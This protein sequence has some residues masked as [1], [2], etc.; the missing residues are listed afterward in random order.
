MGLSPGIIDPAG[1]ATSPIDIGTDDAATLDAMKQALTA[2]RPQQV[3]QQQAPITGELQQAAPTSSAAPQPQAAQPQ[4]PPSPGGKPLLLDYIQNM[5]KGGSQGGPSR[6]DSTLN[7]MGSF[8]QNL[9]QGLAQA[10]HGPGANLRGFAGG[11]QAPYQRQLQQYQLGQQQQAQ[12]S[13]IASEAAKTQQ[14]QAQTEQLKNVV[15]TPY[16]P[17]SAALAAK[18]F[19]AAIN[20]QGKVD[21]AK[22]AATS[23]EDVAGTNAESRE[24]IAATKPVHDSEISLIQKANAGDPDAKAAWD[25]LQAGRVAVRASTQ[26]QKPMT[27]YDAETG[28]NITLSAGEAESMQK[29]GKNLIP[30]GTVPA[31][32]LLQ[33]QKASN[34][35]PAAV[36][37]LGKSLKA[38]DNAGDRAIFAKVM[39]ETPQG[40]DPSTWFNNVLGQAANANLSPEG[41]EALVKMRTLNESLGTLRAISG[42]PSTSGSMMAT[43]A[44]MP[45]ATTPDS[46]MAKQQLDQIK[47]LVQRETGIPFLGGGGG[48]KLPTPSGGA[49]TPKNATTPKK[50]DPLGIL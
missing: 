27:F 47:T 29:Q 42:L 9:A 34:S 41:R 49:A 3:D 17:M 7:F 5:I 2:G 22:V 16:G 8:L 35:I 28:R 15:Q 12:Q 19:P 21:A 33:M 37:D 39:K 30:A 50:G 13:Q 23:R 1:G 20:S 36:D 10:G 14:T 46:K 18:V 4:G 32:T 26:Q 48:T 31:N 6:G 45:G 40:G 38:W 25:K 11:V 44:L 24:K 43:M